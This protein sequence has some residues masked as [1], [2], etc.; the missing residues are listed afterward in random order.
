MIENLE[1]NINEIVNLFYK[2]KVDEG[3]KNI[4]LLLPDIE[5]YLKA[6]GDKI[7]IIELNDILLRL[8]AAMTEKDSIMLA[9]TLKY[10]LIICLKG[11]AV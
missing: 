11:M 8:V 10:E 4:E 9:D 6:F 5:E 7:D 1:K 2:L 3:I